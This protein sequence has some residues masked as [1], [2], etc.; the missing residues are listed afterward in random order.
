MKILKYLL[1]IILSFSMKYNMLSQDYNSERTA[2]A[3]Y[4]QRMYEAQPFEGVRVIDNGDEAYLLSVIVLDEE[5]LGS[6]ASRVASVKA[7]AQTSRFFNESKINSSMVIRTTENG[8]GET[9]TQTIEVINENHV[10]IVKQ[11]ELVRTFKNDIGLT[12]YLFASKITTV[13]KSKSSKR[14]KR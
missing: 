7:T 12:V 6:T 1:V 8:K 4:V 3:N 5:K 13:E 9:I 14:S 2:W 11:L 10:G